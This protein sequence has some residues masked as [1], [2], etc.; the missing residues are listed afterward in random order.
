M[1]LVL[2]LSGCGG[3]WLAT[4]SGIPPDDNHIRVHHGAA[5]SPADSGAAFTPDARGVAPAAS[6]VMHGAAG[7]RR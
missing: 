7:L 6:G 5:E 2:A 3:K 4:F 1:S